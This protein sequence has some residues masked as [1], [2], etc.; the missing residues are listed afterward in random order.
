[1]EVINGKKIIDLTPIITTR[2]REKICKCYDLYYDAKHPRFEFDKVN[3]KIYCRNCGNMVDPFFA[4]EVISKFYERIKEWENQKR[5]EI[6]E[7]Q[8]YKPWKKAIK[9]L[10]SSIGRKGNMLPHCPHC[11][12]AFRLEQVV[13]GCF[14]DETICKN[15][16]WA[17]K[18]NNDTVLRW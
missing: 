7:L 5:Q 18:E 2:N 15:K 13:T 11:G 6:M 12:E 8:G 17:D 10:E 4:M 14:S 16:G 9:S 3:R 1:M